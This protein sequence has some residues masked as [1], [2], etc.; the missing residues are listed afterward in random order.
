[1]LEPAIQCILEN[2]KEY[3]KINYL[4]NYYGFTFADMFAYQDKHNEANGENNKDGTDYNCTWNCGAEG[5]TRKK[6]V[7]ALRYRQMKN[8]FA[9][10]FF[11][12]GMPLIYMGDE[13]ARTQKGNNNPYCQDNDISWVNWKLAEKN[14]ELFKYVKECI[15]LRK[16]H[17]VFST[18]NTYTLTDYLNTGCPDLSFHDKEAWMYSR[19]T[20]EHNIGIL[21]NGDYVPGCE[22][23]LFYVA[24]N[25]YWESREFALPILPDYSVWQAFFATVEEH[26]DLLNGMITLPERSLFVFRCPKES[27]SKK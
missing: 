21:M 12:Q 16:K 24:I 18:E 26:A 19:E 11:S 13:F 20:T 6:E 3:G 2:P 27:H 8:A 7:I 23:N 17:R 9:L 1:M 10:L 15:R 4:S 22:G 14:I 25:T 5:V